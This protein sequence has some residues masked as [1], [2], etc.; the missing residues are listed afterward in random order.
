[1]LGVGGTVKPLWLSHQP[2]WFPREFYWIVGCT[3]QDIPEQPIMVR[4]PYGGC[5]C[6]RRELFA[7]VGGFRSG[8]G[9]A[10]AL[11]LGC[12]ETELCIRA[13]QHWP[14]KI[15]LYEPQAIIHHRIP[16][17]RASWRYFRTRCYAEGLSKAAV[18]RYV[19]T[20][21][22]LASE[23]AYTLRTLPHGVAR[24]LADALIRLDASGFLRAGAIIL[25]LAITIVGYLVGTI[26]QH[27]SPPSSGPQAETEASSISVKG[28]QGETLRLANRATARG[29]RE[30]FVASQPGDRKGHKGEL[31]G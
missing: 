5:S 19:G 30:N 18:A 4:N 25:G 23:R 8:M 2:A 16:L 31:C 22:G 26:T 3:Y 21:D 28:T 24:G 13:R 12:E 29:T 14:Q 27:F 20:Q 17:R 7:V 10:D 9:R 15:F 1:V 11:P 6:L